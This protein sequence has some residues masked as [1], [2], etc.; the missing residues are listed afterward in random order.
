MNKTIFSAIC[1]SA[2]ESYNN[3][4]MGLF[5]VIISPLFFPQM[6]LEYNTCLAFTV[7]ALGFVLRPVG[8]TFFGHIADK[9]GARPLL[10]ST[11]AIISLSSLLIAVCPSYEK[12]GYL[13]SIIFLLCRL[14]QG[15]VIGTDY[16]A[17]LLNL[18]EHKNVKDLI[19][20][21]CILVSL[22]FLGA[23]IGTIMCIITTL[24]AMPDYSWRF[25]FLFNGIAGVFAYKIRSN[26]PD[27]PKP[28]ATEKVALLSSK[29]DLKKNLVYVGIFGGA[30]LVPVYI[31]TIVINYDLINNLKID[32]STVM[33]NNLLILIIGLLSVL[34]SV[35][36]IKH[37]G[38]IKIIE[39]CM[40]FYIFCSI[41]AF[42]VAL[43]FSSPLSYFLLQVLIIIPDAFQIAALTVILPYIFPEDK[44][45]KL[46]ALCFVGGQALV[47]GMTPLYS[48]LL[49]QHTNIEWASGLF[50][51]IISGLYLYCIKHVQFLRTRPA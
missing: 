42:Y 21:Q 31:A 43:M 16:T 20:A 29:I 4:L 23:I 17:A 10:R 49:T 46:L 36:L 3:M 51:T 18:T 39:Y 47:G 7:F 22:G 48:F 2:I 30:N 24:P 50:L 27:K 26:I 35:N 9:Y 32:S 28:L 37:Y 6:S 41:P 14:S 44:K 19:S 1:G 15:L 34:Y 38:P 45:Y 12:A 33:V 40:Y 25:A 11:V 13:S 5:S 8:G